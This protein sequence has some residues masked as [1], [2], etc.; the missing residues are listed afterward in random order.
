MAETVKLI[1]GLRA[2]VVKDGK[3][4][5]AGFDKYACWCEKTMERKASDISAAKELITETEILIKKL[6]GE[7]A[8][9]GAE[10][11]QLNKDIAENAAAQKDA[12]AVRD[13]EYKEYSGERSESE[14][15]IGALEAAIKVLTGAGEGKG[16]F[17]QNPSMRQAELLSVVAGLRKV[18]SHKV[19]AGTMS[20]K[21]VQMIKHFV[22]K[23]DDF[24]GTKT[25]SAAQISQNPFGD[26]APQS[27]QIQGILQGMYDAFTADLEKDNAAEADSE[28][29]FR[30]LMATKKQE[31]KTLQA[32][33]QKQESDHAAKSK[34]LSESQVLKDDTAA[35][36]DADEDFFAD[37]K[38]ACQTK[39]TQWS[40]RTRLRTEELNGMDVAIKILS[41]DDAKKTF[42][43]STSTFVQ[44]KSVQQ[45]S[46]SSGA[47]A[48]AYN[49]LRALASQLKS[50]NIARMAVT[51][52]SGGHFDKVIAMIDQMMEVLRAEE[53]DD[54]AHRDRC[55]N[56]QNANKNQMADLASSIK[57]TNANIK[58][59]ENTAGEKQSEIDQLKKEIK[60][61]E[62]DQAELL[63][64]RNKEE[65][66]FKQALKDDMDAAELLR[67]A[68]A[69]LEAF[70]KRNKMDV[71]ALIQ[72]Q[73]EY[74]K[75]EDKAPDAGFEGA[76]YGG[77][78]SESGGILAILQML[79]EDTEKEM[80]EGRRD[81]ADAQEKYLKQNGALQATHDSLS[82]TK[83]ATE[84]ELADLEEKIAEA[85][86]FK[87]Q[88][89]ADQ[90]AEKDQKKALATDCDWVKSN[91]QSRRDKRKAEMQGLVDAKSFLAGAQ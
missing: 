10:I 83:A 23:P 56:G 2:E 30:E 88:R 59:M 17:L 1:Q 5:Q 45:H 82:D 43:S 62:D 13:K 51:L 68:I 4:E 54:I 48:T 7:I 18:L 66:D 79:V 15:C 27:T 77:R 80:G 3:N 31:Q 53:A 61:A 87:S 57:K 34:K 85:E 8:S 90:K 65:A 38:D 12:A 78:K 6:K 9:H 46:E 28:K 11:E 74:A 70:Y 64:F 25:M 84:T 19:V 47:R 37:T 81:N 39:A 35:Q 52:K 24:V 67:K 16:A 33:L 44:L 41:S 63:D 21:D 75:D 49:K 89:Q 73:P 71:P 29:S 14:N 50:R 69:A 32:T 55:E 36:L 20:E 40:I 60:D 91:F 72:K 58:R 22:E 42:K 86:G 26:Y 76:D